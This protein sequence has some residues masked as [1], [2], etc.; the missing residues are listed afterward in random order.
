MAVPDIL[1]L[2]GTTYRIFG[3]GS[4]PSWE[5]GYAIDRTQNPM[6]CGTRRTHLPRHLTENLKTVYS[7][8]SHKLLDL[9]P[10]L[11]RT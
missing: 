1:R 3:T 9:F 2:L 10:P 7:R 5:I 4:S 11:N 6:K 8:N